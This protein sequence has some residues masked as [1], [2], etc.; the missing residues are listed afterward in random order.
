MTKGQSKK[1]YQNLERSIVKLDN[2]NAALTD[3][4]KAA[5]AGKSVNMERLRNLV[6]K[7][8]QRNDIHTSSRAAYIAQKNTRKKI[9][10]RTK[11]IEKES[12]MPPA[13][14]ATPSSESASTTAYNAQA[15]RH[16]VTNIRTTVLVDGTLM[17]DVNIIESEMAN[18]TTT[19]T[20]T[21]T[22]GAPRRRQEEEWSA[23]ATASPATW[24]RLP[25]SIDTSRAL[26]CVDV[27]WKDSNKANT[28][29]Q[30]S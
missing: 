3:G 2:A 30:T 7:A 6:E 23:N 29:L 1:T 5:L 21:T 4:E 8:K 28:R 14:H 26:Q 13:D 16:K 9:N 25:V 22:I 24:A 20:A 10:D 11:N 12:K 18:T 17:Q 15:K 27:E 19:T